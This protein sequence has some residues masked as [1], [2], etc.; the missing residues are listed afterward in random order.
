WQR[1]ISM[2]AQGWVVEENRKKMATAPSIAFSNQPFSNPAHVVV[3]GVKAGDPIYGRVT[4]PKP[5]KEYVSMGTPA[6]LQI[7]IKCLNDNVSGLS[8][9]KLLRASEFENAYIDFDIF[10]SSENARDVY[11]SNLGFYYTIF[12]TGITPGR[13]LEFEISLASDYN[14]S[15]N[16]FHKMDGFYGELEIDYAGLTSQQLK[17][18]NDK[19]RKLGEEAE[20]N[21]DKLA[22]IEG[23][24]Q[25]KTL[26]LP[27][28]FTRASKSGYSGYSNAA[29]MQMIKAKF[30]ATEVLMLTFDESDGH[31]DFTALT[32]LSNYPTEKSGNH[33]F[34]FV[35]KDPLDGLYKFSGGRLRMLYEGNGRY[36]EAYIFPY[37]PIMEGDPVFPYDPMRKKLGFDSIFFFDA[38]KIKR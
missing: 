19:G 31:G 30:K 4:L 17:E 35:F 36:G 26:P 7:D 21:A 29:I 6:K 2:A 28:V 34:Y 23:A 13:K 16:Y 14:A 11:S 22:G 3:S 38:Q 12:A 18:L 24:A 9:E 27:I 33:V 32:D 8:V 10:P 25:V 37:S 5:L 1:S 15:N 20:E